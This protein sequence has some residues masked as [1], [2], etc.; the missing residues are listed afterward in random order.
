MISFSMDTTAKA[1]FSYSFLSSVELP[2]TSPALFAEVVKEWQTSTGVLPR[3]S[4]LTLLGGH[5][6]ANGSVP[7]GTCCMLAWNDYRAPRV[8]SGYGVI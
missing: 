5:V 1:N 2:E 6:V 3:P 4:M 7:P 8:F